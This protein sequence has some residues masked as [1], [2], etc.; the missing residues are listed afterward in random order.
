MR[1][2]EQRLLE[3]VH[4]QALLAHLLKQRLR[5]AADGDPSAGWLLCCAAVALRRLVRLLEQRLLDQVHEQ[6]LL[7]QVHEQAL[8]AHLLEQRLLEKVQKQVLLARLH[9]QCIFEQV[10][11]QALVVHSAVC[12]CVILRWRL[13]QQRH[14]VHPLEQ[15]HL[16]HILLRLRLIVVVVSHAPSA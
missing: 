16:V 2:L 4:E 12:C 10:H 9:K 11:E 6:R 15:R 3:Q 7:D 14:L 5:A 8:L 1:L 13:L